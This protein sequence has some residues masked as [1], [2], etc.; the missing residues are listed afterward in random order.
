MVTGQDVADFLGQGDD[1]ALVALAERHVAVIAAMAQAYT[2]GR[3]FFTDGEPAEDV[4]ADPHSYTGRFLARMLPS[5]AAR[6]QTPAATAHKPDVRPPRRATA[7]KT[8]S[9]PKKKAAE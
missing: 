6:P 8:S 2:R 5:V 9:S 4:A 1:T 3:G 7:K